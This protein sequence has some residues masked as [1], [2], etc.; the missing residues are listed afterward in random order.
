MIRNL[1]DLSKKIDGL[2]VEVVQAINDVAVNLGIPFFIVGA[3][4]R[5]IILRYGYGIETIRATVDIDLAVRVSNWEQY[6][7]LKG[8]LTKTGLF[9]EDSRQAQRILYKSGFPIDI[10]PFGKVEDQ[11]GLVSWPP[12]YDIKINTFGFEEA[13]DHSILVRLRSDPDLDV[14]FASLEGQAILKLI[15]WDDN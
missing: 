12:D 3:A 14:R 8:G 9:T 7:M 4:A 2:T 11:N 10:I 6:N 13:F 5:D 1:L 15:S